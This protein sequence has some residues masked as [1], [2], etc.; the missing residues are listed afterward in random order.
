MCTLRLLD[1]PIIAHSRGALCAALGFRNYM[2]YVIRHRKSELDST[3]YMEIG[4]GRYSGAHWQDGFLFVWEDAFGMAEG[5]LSKYFPEYDHFATNEI[6]KSVGLTI[7]ANWEQVASLLP[8][9][10]VTE[11]AEALNLVAS[12]RSG[13]EDEIAKHSASICVMLRELSLSCRRFYQTSEWIC[14]IGM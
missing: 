2:D 6:P 9:S 11:A 8:Q 10:N 7:I 12:Y 1:V 14:V 4:P 3:G 5:I 13:L